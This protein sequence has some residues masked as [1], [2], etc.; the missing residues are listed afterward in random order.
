MNTFTGK[1]IIMTVPYHHHVIGNTSEGLLL[2][3]RTDVDDNMKLLN[4][5]T[6]Q[7]ISNLPP[8][9]TLGLHKD[10]R[11]CDIDLRGAGVADDSTVVLHFKSFSLALAKPGDERWT[12]LYSSSKR[13]LST[14]QF[15]GR[16]YCATETDVSVVQ[17]VENQRPQLVVAAAYQLDQSPRGN[18]RRMHFSDRSRMFLVDHNGE[19]I[20][21]HHDCC[22]PCI[23]GSCYL[24]R[25][26]LDAGYTVP[27]LERLNNGHALFIS[28]TRSVLAG[29]GVSPVIRPDTVYLCAGTN[30]AFDRLGTCAERKFKKTDAANYLTCYVSS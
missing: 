22:D 7:M 26:D 5:I 20:A 25:V 30:I 10:F 4:P 21:C 14:L 12:Q 27:L 24:Y 13:I 28:T 29:S 16:V 3:G 8:A 6:G 15:A 2:L 1:R 17:T 18:A 11:L 23:H 19:L 9:S